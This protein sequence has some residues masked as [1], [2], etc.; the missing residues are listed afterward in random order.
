MPVFTN[1]SLFTVVLG[2]AIAL[3]QAPSTPA[4]KTPA[5][6]VASAQMENRDQHIHGGSN[7][8]LRV[9]LDHPLPVGARFDARLSPVTV[10]QEFTVS[11]G[12]PV[13]R[14]RREF[15]LKTKLPDEALPGEWHI[16][17]VYLFMSGSSWTNSTIAVNDV[18]F[19]VEGK[20][21]ELPKKAT[22]TIEANNR[23]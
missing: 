15:L 18:R 19:T 7:I 1:V 12:E 10:L 6:T 23:P 11:S 22:V 17:T 8:V 5:Q 16:S 2:G 13:D 20:P 14:E 21:I 4:V 9:T 3:A